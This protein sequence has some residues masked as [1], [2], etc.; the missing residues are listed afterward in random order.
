[1][2]NLSFLSLLPASVESD[3][4]SLIVKETASEEDLALVESL[5]LTSNDAFPFMLGDLL[6][7]YAKTRGEE[8][9]QMKAHQKYA[10][11]TANNIRWTCRQV[12][13]SRRRPGLTFGHHAE[14][15][16]LT[17]TEQE[18]M[19]TRAEEEDL[20]P[21]ALRAE[22]R[23][24]KRTITT[25]AEEPVI[26]AGAARATRAWQEFFPWIKAQW[27]QMPA[28]QKEAWKVQLDELV[29]LLDEDQDA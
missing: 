14:V 21:K 24:S 29:A 16:K 9:A 1:M 27:P 4:R 3:G 10:P 25:G 13:V 17:P 18:L 8:F 2:Q 15:A 22:V 23:K 7:H 5:L 12:D 6:N 19:L 28:A 20:S 26:D 11:G